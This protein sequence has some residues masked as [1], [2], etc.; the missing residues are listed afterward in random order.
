MNFVTNAARVLTETF[1][2]PTEGSFIDLETGDTVRPHR[3][4]QRAYRRIIH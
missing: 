2:A 1:S 4:V 3:N